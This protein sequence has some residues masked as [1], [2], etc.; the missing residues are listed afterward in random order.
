MAM[1][2]FDTGSSSLQQGAMAP[3]SKT[4]GDSRIE[5]GGFIAGSDSPAFTLTIPRR[6][7]IPVLIAVPHAGRI[8]PPEILGTMREPEYCSIRLEDRFVDALASEVARETGAALLVA[9]APRAMLDLNRAQDDVDWGMVSGSK[10]ARP[11]HSQA[12][13]R[14]RSGLGLVP[15]R[16]HGFGEIWKGHLSQAE[17]MSHE[18]ASEL[19]ILGSRTQFDPDLVEIFRVLKDNFADIYNELDD[20]SHP[21][22]S[23]TKR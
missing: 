20:A 6:Q 10:P 15:R 4:T 9:H 13:R 11:P 19:I 17:E 22:S 5:N 16:L 12:N 14:A 23:G 3:R 18:Q 7:P 2:S 21:H 1:T 8:Y